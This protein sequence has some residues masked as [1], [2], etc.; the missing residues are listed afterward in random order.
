MSGHAVISYVRRDSDRADTIQT[1]LE[2][3]GVRVWRDTRDVW[4]GD[5]PRARI[6][7]A[8]TGDALVF[9]ACFSS[10]GLA[11]VKSSQ[12]DELFLAVDELR[13]RSPGAPW[14]IPVRFDECEIPDIDIGGG[15]T[16]RSLRPADLFGSRRKAELD[17][18]VTAVLRNL[19]T[20]TPSA[21]IK[22]AG[23]RDE[24]TTGAFA[25]AL[26]WLKA[27]WWRPL[28][29][30]LVLILIPTL[31][32][33]GASIGIGAA[34]RGHL[35]SDSPSS[36]KTPTASPVGISTLISYSDADA[37]S[38]AKPVSTGA[39]YAEI[40]GGISDIAGAGPTWSNFLAKTYGA[41]LNELHADIT[42]TGQAS[43]GVRVTNIQIERIGPPMPPLSGTFIPIPHGG[44]Q[45]A[46]RFSANMDSPGPIL[47]RLPSGQSFPDLNVQLSQGEQVTLSIDF[48]AS[49]YTSKWILHLTYLS[50]SRTGH[51]DIREPNGQPFAVTAQTHSYKVIYISNY[52]T[53]AGYHL[54]RK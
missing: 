49:H 21:S 33:F 28:A 25:A 19:G 29:G 14:L 8:I 27:R 47:T 18:L 4:P 54:K 20:P 17:R 26:T 42:L 1:A 40:A 50:G 44:A 23:T 45:A 6:R 32:V 51:L 13:L 53:G 36:F 37:I 5:D 39:G 52:P 24:P 43:K 22:D 30:G 3:A 48:K 35:S 10:R 16:L 11:V 41:P 46:F 38:M 12:R 15:Q 2:A 9:L 7:E 31:S 34:H